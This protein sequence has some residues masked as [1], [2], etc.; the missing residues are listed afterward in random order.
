MECIK[1]STHTHAHTLTFNVKE[2]M[3]LKERK[4]GVREFGG[5]NLQ[6]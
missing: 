3:N 6:K 1:I 2:A 5:W 4:E